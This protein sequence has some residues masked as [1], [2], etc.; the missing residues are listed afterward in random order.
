MWKFVR[1]AKFSAR[2]FKESLEKLDCQWMEKDV[3]HKKLPGF[4]FQIVLSLL[5][6]SVC[7]KQDNNI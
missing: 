4:S 5:F 2:K 6:R 7:L 1:N 3:T